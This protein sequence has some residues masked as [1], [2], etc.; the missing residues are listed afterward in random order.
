MWRWV[1]DSV[2]NH[3]RA[4]KIKMRKSENSKS[5]PGNEAEA[6]EE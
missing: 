2:K 3:K 5:D 1:V 6:S 4:V